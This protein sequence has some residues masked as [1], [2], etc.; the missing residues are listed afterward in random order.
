[1]SC[2]KQEDVVPPLSAILRLVIAS[3][4]HVAAVSVARSMMRSF[5]RGGRVGWLHSWVQFR[6]PSFTSS[7][8]NAL[9]KEVSANANRGSATTSSM[10]V[11]TCP[12]LEIRP[13]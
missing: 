6:Y 7:E 13:P 10:K 5:V 11:H 2:K 1:M 4:Q 8:Y 12:I 9:P 3:D